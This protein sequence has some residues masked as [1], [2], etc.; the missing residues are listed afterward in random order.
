MLSEK[1]GVTSGMGTRPGALPPCKGARAL[2]RSVPNRP[3]D[4]SA[5]TGPAFP[6]E[7]DDRGIADER[8]GNA[9]PRRRR[10]GGPPRRDGAADRGATVRGGA[11]ATGGGP[12]TR[13]ADR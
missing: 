2:L 4:A 13:G 10:D 6:S 12:D 5:T 11:L 8:A 3:C 1:K 7:R 9:P